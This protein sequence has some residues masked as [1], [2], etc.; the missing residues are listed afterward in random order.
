MSAFA[1]AAAGPLRADPSK[2]VNYT[3]G[4]VLGVDEFQQDQLYHTAGRRL[5]E[6]LLHGYGT[7]WGLQVTTP[8]PGESDPEIRVTAGVAVD[9]CGREI[10]VGDTM[11]V[12]LNAWLERHRALL[13]RLYGTGPATLPLAV[14]LC[15]RECPDDVVPVPGEPCRSQDDAMQPSRIRDSFELRLAL[16]DEAPWDS[17]PGDNP[18]GLATFRFSQPEEEAA[19]AFGRLL[20]RVRVECR[21]PGAGAGGAQ[22]LL[23]AVR[24]LG[25][26][27]EWEEAGSPP[28]GADWIVLDP[29]EAE[30]ALRDAVRVWA[31]EVRPRVRRLETSG[32]GCCGCGCGCGDDGCVLLAEVDLPVTSTWTVQG[33]VFDPDER[34][35]PILLH[36]RLL[37]EWLLRWPGCGCCAEVDTFV[38]AAPIALDTIRAWLHH[39][40]P[41]SLPADAVTVV[42]NG[43]APV[44][45]GSVT[46]VGGIDNAFDV[47]MSPGAADGDTVELRFDLTLIAEADSA[48]AEIGAECP[49]GGLLDRHGP[50]VSA[51]VVFREQTTVLPSFAGDLSGAFPTGTV[52]GLQ[53][54]PVSPAAPANTQVLTWNGAAWIP[55]N[56]PAAAVP[57]AGGD[58]TGTLPALTVVRLQGR[59]VSAAAPAA[60]QVLTWDGAQWVPAPV[61]IPSAA[62]DVTGNVGNL[63]VVRLQGRDMPNV[64]P[65]ASQV[66][67]WNGT[68]WVPAN[69]P[70]PA[71]PPAAGDATG[72]L[73]ALTVVGLQGRPVSGA[74]PGPQQ[75][76]TWNGARWEPQFAVHSPGG[77]YRIVA[78]GVFSGAGAA[79][80]TVYNRTR[81]IVSPRGTP[82]SIL[83]ILVQFDGF[84]PR[85]ELTYVVKGTAWDSQSLIARPVVFQRLQRDGLMT[86]VNLSVEGTDRVISIDRIMIEINRIG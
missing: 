37:Q 20:E 74:A 6:R 69:L 31:T 70:P 56:V 78:A 32:E 23:A 13:Q 49:S 16:R 17:P 58:A 42:V 76:L 30:G 52:I 8:A 51:F 40:A 19:R 18:G 54:H 9:P 5:H 61:A 72:A 64:A 25:A 68:G 41:L 66:L 12:R 79:V 53:G 14:V 59:N 21:D 86:G 29:A 82:A 63:R 45:P 73:G 36:T 77:I 22:A 39:P 85:A 7:V 44:A 48:P 62:G 83:D 34:R 11:C 15:Y 75:V 67:T 80:G 50:E 4:L 28:A 27:V 26:E 65:A 84:E 47:L 38:T 43:G 81:L 2:R 10:C 33:T 71:I 60:T 35:R 46:A 57:P 1:T 3:L 24:A 55:A